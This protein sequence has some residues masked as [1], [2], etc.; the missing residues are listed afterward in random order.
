MK[1]PQINEKYQYYSLAKNDCNTK[2]ALL[3]ILIQ[4]NSLMT[5]K[6]FFG[7]PTQKSWLRQ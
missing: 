7:P 3:S 4:S 6:S 1:I 5:K 2:I